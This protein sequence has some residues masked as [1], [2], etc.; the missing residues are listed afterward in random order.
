MDVDG[1]RLSAAVLVAASGIWMGGLLTVP[2]IAV[3]SKR[4]IEP[5][6]R[7]DLFVAFGRPFAVIMGVVL[8]ISLIASLTLATSSG[9]RLAPWTLGLVV[10]LLVVTAVGIVQAR[11]MSGLR[12]AAAKASNSALLGDLRRNTIMATALRSLIGLLSVALLVSAAWL[13]STS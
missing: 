1:E 8:T 9:S 6:A 12:R 10:A 5:A 13:G 4:L 2:I 3:T 7:A 11:K